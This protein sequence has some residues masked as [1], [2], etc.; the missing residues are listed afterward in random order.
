MATTLTHFPLEGPVLVVDDPEE[1]AAQAVRAQ[2]RDVVR[3]SRMD[4]PG[5]EVG[6]PW[7]SP[8]P[9]GAALVR[10]PPSRNALDFL[11]H[12]VGSV[13]APGGRIFVYGS[14]DEGIASTG[15]RMEP[16][17]ETVA[18]R[19]NARRCRVLEGQL[20]GTDSRPAHGAE[21][22]AWRTV[23]TVDFGWGPVDWVSYPGTFAKG[24]VDPGTTLLLTNLP[25]WPRGG[26]VLD[27][28]A[29][30]GV[31]AAVMAHRDPTA[32]VVMVE[33]DALS[34]EA[35]GEN[36]PGGSFAPPYS[37][38]EAGPFHAIVSN[39]PY[40]RGKEE[41]LEVLASLIARAPGALVSGG[42][43][44]IV[45][46]RRLPVEPLLREGFP[47]PEVVVDEGPYRVWRALSL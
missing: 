42:E 44:R 32:Q 2:G 31:L 13:V 25:L 5:G 4:T 23:S 40:H 9:F 47:A 8:G 28:A 35:A 10:L 22:S 14:K 43:L 39:P 24:G 20:K 45:V 15:R 17:V 37:W 30:T 46:Q 12:A 36:V 1:D 29:G 18:V 6:S 16:W 27:F 3:W 21:L 7:P 33:P 34:R 38:W 19:A 26:R 11:L 41:S